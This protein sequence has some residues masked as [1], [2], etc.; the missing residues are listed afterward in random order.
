MIDSISA[1]SARDLDPELC[2]R[3]DLGVFWFC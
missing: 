1:W 2:A 3:V